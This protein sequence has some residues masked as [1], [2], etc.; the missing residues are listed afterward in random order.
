LDNL[1][2]LSE[3]EK[4]SIDAD[5]IALDIGNIPEDCQRCKFLAVGLSDSTVR[6]FS[7]DPESCL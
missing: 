4:I 2:Q 6:L 1:G 7:L 5:I 3:I